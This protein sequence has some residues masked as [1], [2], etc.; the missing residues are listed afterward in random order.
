MPRKKKEALTAP[1]EGT[2]TP[3]M[4][5]PRKPREDA[6]ESAPVVPL[7]IKLIWAAIGFVVAILLIARQRTTAAPSALATIEYV[8][9]LGEHVADLTGKHNA[10]VKASRQKDADFQSE[11]DGLERRVKKLETPPAAPPSST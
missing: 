3:R 2:P 11:L 6:D 5:R 7:K 10:F 1:V 8:D 9:G 4:R